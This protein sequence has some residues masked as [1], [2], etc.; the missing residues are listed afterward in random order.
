MIQKRQN[1]PVI[2]KSLDAGEVSIN[3]TGR[4]VSGYL[5][6]FDNKDS[7]GDVLLKG[8]FKRSID[9]RGP[10]STTARKIAYLY[11]HDMTKPIGKFTT[12]IEDDKGLYFEAQLDD[13][14]LSDDVLTQ[15]MSGTL[16]QHSIGFR[17]IWDKVK[18][19]EASQSYLIA[20]VD[21][22]EGSVVTL[23]ANENTPFTGLK[24]DNIPDIQLR[25]NRETEKLIKSIEDPEKQ[26][27]IRQLITKHIALTESYPEMTKKHQL[28]AID[29]TKIIQSL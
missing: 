14:D 9:T 1:R 29:Y 20:E 13:I 17:Y 7:D 16:N 5:A 4:T 18:W 22:F 2:Y 12:L 8:C 23:G 26:Y 21:L 19:D 3:E 27:Q 6:A 25:L 24:S 15:Y 10:N 28:P 11:Q